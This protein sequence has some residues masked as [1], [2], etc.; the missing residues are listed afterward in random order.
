MTVL[1]WWAL[2]SVIVSVFIGAFLERGRHASEILE[3]DLSSPEVPDPVSSAP[4]DR[5][6]NLT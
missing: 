6:A 1:F 5:A 3:L 4:V 2:A